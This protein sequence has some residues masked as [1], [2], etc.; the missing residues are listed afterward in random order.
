MTTGCP[1]AATL[2]RIR[3]PETSRRVRA[4]GGGE[5]IAHDDVHEFAALV[6]AMADSEYDA[7][8]EDIRV[9]G[10]MEAII[11][12]EGKILDGRHR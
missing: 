12:F 11:L 10:F 1:D 6:P 9:N 4:S 3:E 7:F 5:L 8:R 2:G